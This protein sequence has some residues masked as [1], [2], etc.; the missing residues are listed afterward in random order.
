MKR[1]VL[2]CGGIKGGQSLK[3]PEGERM[4]DSEGWNKRNCGNCQKQYEPRLHLELGRYN[5]RYE[6]AIDVA[7]VGDG[8]VSASVAKAIGLNEKTKKLYMWDC[9]LR[10]VEDW[11]RVEK[12]PED[13]NDVLDLARSLWPGED[14]EE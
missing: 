10:Q 6:R 2:F 7:S 4:R 14:E 13:K 3:V 9:P 1:V 11:G 8:K 12:T 5:C